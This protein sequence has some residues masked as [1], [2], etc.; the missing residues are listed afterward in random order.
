M[1]ALVAITLAAVVLG[2]LYVWMKPAPA[3]VAQPRPANAMSP[4]GLAAQYGPAA[5]RDFEITIAQG[6]IASGGGALRVTQGAPVVIRVIS[7]HADELH[8][9]GYDLELALR[10]GVPGSLAFTADKAGRFELEL[11]HAHLELGALEVQPK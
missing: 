11:H 4:E 2:V 3:P 8:L 9:H 6:R 7:D 5:A 1:R 10:S